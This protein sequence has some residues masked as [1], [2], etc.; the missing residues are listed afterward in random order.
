HRQELSRLFRPAP[1][2][3]LLGPDGVSRAGG[4]DRLPFGQDV[5]I[6][7]L[8]Q[9]IRRLRDHAPAVV[10]DCLPQDFACLAFDE[11]GWTLANVVA[12]DVEEAALK[13]LLLLAGQDAKGDTVP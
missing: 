13:A 2:D 9:L 1:W 3:W 12:S 10:L 6:P 4:P 8:D 11:D 7:R 5:V